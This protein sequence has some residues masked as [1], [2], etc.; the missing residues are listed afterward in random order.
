[1]GDVRFFLDKKKRHY[2]FLWNLG[3]IFADSVPTVYK[4][5]TGVTHCE[6]I[7]ISA[8]MIFV[9]RPT[10][11]NTL[12]LC[13][14]YDIDLLFLIIF[15]FFQG[16]NNK[17]EIKNRWKLQKNNNFI[18]KTYLYCSLYSQKAKIFIKNK[19]KQNLK[20]EHENCTQK[21]IISLRWTSYLYGDQKLKEYNKNIHF[22]QCF[23]CQ[24]TQ[25]ENTNNDAYFCHRNQWI[26][27]EK[28]CILILGNF[29][30]T[31]K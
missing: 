2:K 16:I 8:K 21:H 19:R 27:L 10:K 4:F 25:K 15:L 11:K 18:V 9:T 28:P 17:K 13:L 14:C 30:N 24:I 6:K 23:F 22:S 31:H 20:K 26:A 29:S 12:R 7:E 3:G 5:F 1:M